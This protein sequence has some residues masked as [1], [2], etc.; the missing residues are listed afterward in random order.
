M[1]VNGTFLG[2]TIALLILVLFV[3]I[4][5]AG[6]ACDPASTEALCKVGGS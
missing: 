4:V 6:C 5:F 1:D 2:P 3:A